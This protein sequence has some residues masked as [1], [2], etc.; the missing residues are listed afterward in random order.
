MRRYGNYQTEVGSPE[1]Q[2]THIFKPQ[3]HDVLLRHF[4]LDL[5]LG[6][7]TVTILQISDLHFNYLNEQDLA[8]KNPTLLATVINRKWLANA[9]SVQRCEELFRFVSEFPHDQL[10]VTGDCLDYLS[11]GAIELTHKYLW[12]PYPDA[13]ITTGNHEYYQVMFNHPRE[14]EVPIVPETLTIE[15]RIA[16]LEA[17]WKHDLYYTSRVLKD[18]V[19]V[20]QLDNGRKSFPDR[21]VEPLKADLTLAREKGYAVLLFFHIP[22]CTGNPSETQV[23]C[24]YYGDRGNATPKDFYRNSQGIFVGGPQEDSD[25]ATA[26]VLDLIRN[27][28]DVI[29]G[30]FNGHKHGD[31]YTEFVA[32]TPD[33][34][35]VYIPQ[36]TLTASAYP[37]GNAV[38]IEIN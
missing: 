27:H 28:G 8:E 11:H 38:V 10:M 9:E 21:V 19:M 15:E 17:A 7:E 20:I 4:A 35:T 18:K 2:W 34:K 31:Y 12:E 1:N 32:A 25:N 23:M 33:G 6:G 29:R 22:L 3:D 30:L 37:P 13:L 16:M 36:Y 5:G 26:N 14:T 24:H